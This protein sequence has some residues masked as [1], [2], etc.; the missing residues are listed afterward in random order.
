MSLEQLLLS[1]MSL[2]G[3]NANLDKRWSRDCE[4]GILQSFPLYLK[5]GLVIVEVGHMGGEGFKLVAKLDVV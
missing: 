4:E 2:A 1:M 5:S 3:L